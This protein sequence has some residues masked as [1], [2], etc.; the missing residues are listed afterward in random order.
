ME[1]GIRFK[2]S[3]VHIVIRYDIRLLFIASIEVNPG[4]NKEIPLRACTK[5]RITIV[6]YKDEDL[7][8]L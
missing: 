7:L 4:Q 6:K 5:K 2:I 1:Y 8:L 3:F